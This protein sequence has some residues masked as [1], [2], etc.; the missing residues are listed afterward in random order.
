MHYSQSEDDLTCCAPA[1]VSS[2]R[3]IR[4]WM[5]VNMRHTHMRVCS[6]KR[7]AVVGFPSK[8]E[9]IVLDTQKPQCSLQDQW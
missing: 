4:W 8:S 9:L 5:R 2:A 1:S 7:T 6:W 3:G